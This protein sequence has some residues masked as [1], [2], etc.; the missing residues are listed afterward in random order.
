VL[1][2]IN[3]KAMRASLL[4]QATATSLN[5][6]DG[7]DGALLGQPHWSP[8]FLTRTGSVQNAW[9]DARDD[10]AHNVITVS[11]EIFRERRLAALAEWQTLAA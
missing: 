4:A 7:V 6:G 3:A 1:W 2:R 11:R 9:T 5:Y 8:Q 10:I